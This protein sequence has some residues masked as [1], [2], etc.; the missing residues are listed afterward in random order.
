M[1]KDTYYII[2]KRRNIYTTPAILLWNRTEYFAVPII[3][4]A[5]HWC[6]NFEG[7]GCFLEL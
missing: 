6:S 4:S 3:T 7:P 5:S 1:V 2:Y